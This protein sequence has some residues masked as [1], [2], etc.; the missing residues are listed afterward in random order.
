MTFELFSLFAKYLI[1]Y[2]Q[3]IE[4]KNQMKYLFAYINTFINVCAWNISQNARQCSKIKNSA[5]KFY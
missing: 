2:L 5:K 3:N 4:K 1:D